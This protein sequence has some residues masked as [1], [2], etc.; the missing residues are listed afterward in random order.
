MDNK[1]IELKRE[2]V[3]R[4]VIDVLNDIKAVYETSGEIGTVIHLD[5][6]DI[7]DSNCGD[8]LGHEMKLKVL[9]GVENMGGTIQIHPPMNSKC[10]AIHDTDELWFFICRLLDCIR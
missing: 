4:P 3:L 8:L 10:I 5:T 6:N 9:W 1:T 7:C 2:D